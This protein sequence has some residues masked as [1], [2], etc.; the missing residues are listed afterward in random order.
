MIPPGPDGKGNAMDWTR[1]PLVTQVAE[2]A[3]VVSEAEIVL[4]FEGGVRGWFRITVFED[5]KPGDGDRFFARAVEREDP[6]LQAMST[7]AT[8]EEALL[9]KTALEG[10]RRPRRIACARRASPCVARADARARDAEASTPCGGGVRPEVQREPHRRVPCIRPVDAVTAMRRDQ[11]LVARL[12]V[13]GI[14][15][16]LEAQR[17][18]AGEQEYPLVALLVEPLSLGRRLSGR[19]DPLELQVAGLEDRREGLLSR[20]RA[21]G[22]IGEKIPVDHSM[23]SA[24]PDESSRKSFVQPSTPTP[25]IESV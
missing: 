21:R 20:S 3:R 2:A 9:G 10:P 12:Q 5:L 19:D 14:G 22:E 23:M 4:E 15:L 16:V 8:P 7:A 24:Q 1:V 11:D 25:P 6:L 18:G 13:A 17:G